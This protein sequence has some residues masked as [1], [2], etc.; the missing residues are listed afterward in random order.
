MGIDA[1]NQFDID[2]APSEHM[3]F[4]TYT[5]VP[6]VVGRVGTALGE[7]NVNI[8]SMQVGRTEEGG[9]ALMGLNVDTPISDALMERIN[10]K[11][12]VAEAWRIEL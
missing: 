10:A 11:A 6:G 8:A 4:L 9:T 5:D 1:F 3:L 2:M 12:E 7:N